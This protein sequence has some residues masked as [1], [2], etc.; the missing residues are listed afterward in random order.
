MR[1]QLT[2]VRAY[3]IRPLL[4]ATLALA[5]TLTLSCSS[6]DDNDGTSSGSG[7]GTSSSGGGAGN[8][9]SSS[10]TTIATGNEEYLKDRQ[11]QAKYYDPDD[12][13]QRCTTNGVVQRKCK[14]GE[15]FD[16]ATK[17]C[18]CIDGVCKVLGILERL[19]GTTIDE[20]QV[21]NRGT[22]YCRVYDPATG[23]TAVKAM[24]ICGDRYYEPQEGYNR[25]QD[26]VVQRKCN[27][28]E[29]WYDTETQYCSYENNN[30]QTIKA[31]ERCG[32][33]YFTPYDG[34]VEYR[35]KNEVVEE[36]CDAQMYQG[37]N[38]ENA[39]WRDRIKEICECSYEGGIGL[40]GTSTCTVREKQRC[41]S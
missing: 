40:G 34:K 38:A 25:C 8:P 21:Y 1:T 24:E 9:S 31:K 7:A 32:D 4:T 19:C 36:R 11:E 20:A 5:I 28:G 17:N 30:T 26:G 23:T 2:H 10:G 29:D 41:G 37:E 16:A 3:C 22:Q 15:W 14:N 12:E 6:G 13:N 39:T 27:N 33:I 35:C 18:N